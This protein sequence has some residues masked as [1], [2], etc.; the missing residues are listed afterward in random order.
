M[1]YSPVDRDAHVARIPF[2][3]CPVLYL[4][5]FPILT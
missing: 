2:D 1:W 4:V 3:L 5:V